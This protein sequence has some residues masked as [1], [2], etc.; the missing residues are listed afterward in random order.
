MQTGRLTFRPVADGRVVCNQPEYKDRGPLTRKQA[1]TLRVQDFNRTHNRP[2]RKK[3]LDYSNRKKQTLTASPWS[4][5][6]MDCPHCETPQSSRLGDHDCTNCRGRYEIV[7][8][9]RGRFW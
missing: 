1:E 6:K 2:K 9:R 5:D 8:P 7:E 4:G 3:R